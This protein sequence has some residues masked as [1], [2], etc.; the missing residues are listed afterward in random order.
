MS[1]MAAFDMIVNLLSSD[2]VSSVGAVFGADTS[3]LSFGVAAT[4]CTPKS[5]PGSFYTAIATAWAN[6]GYLTHSDVL[7]FLHTTNFGKWAI[8]LYIVAA[9]TGLLGVATNSPM[10]NYTWF[11]IG[12]A[13]YSFLVGTTMQ[14]TGVNWVV[15]NKAVPDMSEVWRNA[16]TG[17]ANTRL[18]KDGLIRINGREGP[19][20]QYEVA[21]PMV[22]LDELFSATTNILIEW[23]G[24]GRQAA[25][26]GKT[27]LANPTGQAEGPWWIMSTLKWEY[28]EN[29]VGATARNPD[30]RDA[31]VTFLGSECGEKFKEGINS[32]AYIAA[33][34]A[35][36]ASSSVGHGRGRG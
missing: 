3:S 34:Q 25:G 19:T 20:S 26:T 35:R 33:T 6:I 8:I 17:L 27:N 30:V 2:I 14:V 12:P 4:K 16:E 7:R 10:R 15:A 23:T 1:M 36:G 21:M 18:A 5:C 13:L 31:L 22:F 28:L 29:I 11:F 9:I 24:I 32:G